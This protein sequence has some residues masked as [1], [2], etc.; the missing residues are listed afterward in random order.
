[1]YKPSV[2]H[3]SLKKGGP[4]ICYT[5]QLTVDNMFCPIYQASSAGWEQDLMCG[6]ATNR[7]LMGVTGRGSQVAGLNHA[8][9]SVVLL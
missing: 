4:I 1:M 6:E 8:H 9:S 3:M 2:N 7:L 5:E